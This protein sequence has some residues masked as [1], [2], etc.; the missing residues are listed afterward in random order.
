MSKPGQFEASQSLQNSFKICHDV[1]SRTLTAKVVHPNLIE[2]L[3]YFINLNLQ[4]I[5]PNQ[6]VVKSNLT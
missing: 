4:E 6:P 1:M 5:F 3:R 2:I